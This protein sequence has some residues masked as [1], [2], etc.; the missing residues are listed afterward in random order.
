MF[1][2][3]RRLSYSQLQFGLATLLDALTGKA[4]R[5]DTAI[6]YVCTRAHCPHT[7]KDYS[8][9]AVLN[10]VV[11]VLG[12]CPGED[13]LFFSAWLQT[14]LSGKSSARKTTGTANPRGLHR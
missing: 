6:H 11:S 3:I 8:K 13:G 9:S 5:F 14:M 10:Q 12:A 7:Y 2:G 1:G 4:L